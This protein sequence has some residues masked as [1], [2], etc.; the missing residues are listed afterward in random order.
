MYKAVQSLNKQYGSERSQ[1]R[2]SLRPVV[3]EL[4][5]F[6]FFQYDRQNGRQG[7]DLKYLVNGLSDS[8]VRDIQR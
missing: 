6:K 5:R 7:L 3:P 8:L 2:E 1:N 4:S